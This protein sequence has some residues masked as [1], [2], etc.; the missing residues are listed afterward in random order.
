MATLVSPAFIPHFLSAYQV[1]G[2]RDYGHDINNRD[3]PIDAGLR[4]A[5]KLAKPGGFIGRDALAKLIDQGPQL[6][7]WFSSYSTNQ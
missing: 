2:F 7:D 5:V 6:D 4:F 1:K 3:T